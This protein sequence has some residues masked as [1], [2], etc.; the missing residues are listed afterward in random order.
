MEKYN[1]EYGANQIQV[2]EGL[3]AVSRDGKGEGAAGL[4]FPEVV[5]DDVG[6]GDRGVVRQSHCNVLSVLA[7][8]LRKAEDH[9][10]AVG[11]GRLHGGHLD[12][13][14]TDPDVGVAGVARLGLVNHGGLQRRADLQTEAVVAA[15]I[16]AVGIGGN[17][18]PEVGIAGLVVGIIGSPL[19]VHDVAVQVGPLRDILK[20]PLGVLAG[21]PLAKLHVR[22]VGRGEH[23]VVHA[24]LDAHPLVDGVPGVGG[25]GDLGALRGV[26]HGQV[27]VDGVISLFH[28]EREG[29]V[30]LL[31]LTVAV[32][33]LL[34]HF[35]GD[36]D[37]GNIVVQGHGL[38]NAGG[39]ESGGI[40]TGGGGD[41][42]RSDFQL[43]AG[44]LRGVQ[45]LAGGLIVAV[46][47]EFLPGSVTGVLID[48]LSAA[49][50]LIQNTGNSSIGVE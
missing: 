8:A 46:L 28:V 12:V 22:G 16:R 14:G 29:V 41:A 23:H 2:L 38:H 21:P 9:A 26:P 24:V 49:V 34:D 15:H 42:V 47:V 6:L 3:E 25:A 50:L 39:P 4:G 27:V 11:L 40:Q 32:M 37:P 13:F 17:A 5:F 1:H 33:G 19:V 20:I 44:L 31:A 30:G 18:V 35:V 10:L 43:P 7:V 48:Q 45:H 36:V